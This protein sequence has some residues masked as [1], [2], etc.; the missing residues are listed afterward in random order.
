M[1]SLNPK[2]LS[3]GIGY[4]A[5]AH[6][7]EETKNSDRGAPVAIVAAIGL[8]SVLGFGYILALIFSI[9]V[10]PCFSIVH[11]RYGVDIKRVF[12]WPPSLNVILLLTVLLTV[13]A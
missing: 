8:S 5:C 2:D 11:R 7:S 6:M 13:S 9:Q 12:I 4:D 3:T 1:F 10:C